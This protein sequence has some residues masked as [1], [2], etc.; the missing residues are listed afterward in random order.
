[1]TKK[2]K[3]ILIIL[4]AVL[5]VS[6]TFTALSFGGVFFGKLSTDNG[7][8]FSAV[9]SSEFE[10]DYPLVQ[11][12]LEDVFYEAYPNGNIK[13]YKYSDNTFNEVSGVKTKKINVVCSYQK[14]PITL[15]Y[16]DDTDVGTIGYGLFSVEQDTSI[17][18]F[19]YIFARLIDCPTSYESSARTNHVLLLDMD[20]EDAYK[21]DKTYSDIYSFDMSSGTS[22][23]I[24]SSRD[25]IVQEDATQDENWTIFTDSSV[26]GM[27]HYDWFATTRYH[28]TGA[29]KL[30]YDFMSVES[31]RSVRKA[32]ATVL[33]NSPSYHL[34]EKDGS[35]YCFSDNDDGFNLIK[36][37]KKDDVLKEF[38][39]SFTEYAV[40]GHH[41]F[42]P[43]SMEFTDVYTGETVSVK[44]ASISSLSGFATS[45]GGTQFAVFCGGD[46]QAMIIYDLDNDRAEITV[47]TDIFDDGIANYCFIN[48]KTLVVSCYAQGGTALNRIVT[49]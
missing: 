39:G 20:A 22:T 8:A 19:S 3:L 29:E 27:C 1:M 6:I 47:S 43:S 14:I 18:T 31:S 41:I 30:L 32:S 9:V 36:N 40:S 11:T 28:D 24:V 25:R 49:L 13:Y 16:M 45:P 44:K 38:D 4:S 5:V 42:D 12:E 46:T 26:N 2:N 10:S 17:K 33:V 37:G 15:Y 48:N 34:W 7:T 23:L 21:I 35:V